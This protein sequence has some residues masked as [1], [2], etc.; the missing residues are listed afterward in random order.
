M[1]ITLF[2]CSVQFSPKKSK[3]RKVDDSDPKTLALGTSG[4]SVALYSLSE[5]KVISTLTDG[6]IHPVSSLCWTNDAGLYST[7]GSEV[8]H[9]DISKRKIK[10]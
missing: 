10:R 9:W 3:K 5:G 4:G 7:A 2:V 8:A 1:I 6:H